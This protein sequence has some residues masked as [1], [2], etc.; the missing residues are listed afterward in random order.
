MIRLSGF[1]CVALAVVFV[2]SL[3][4]SHLNL[5]MIMVA[6]KNKGAAADPGPGDGEREPGSGA[7]PGPGEHAGG[8][9]PAPNRSHGGAGAPGLR[10]ADFLFEE[11]YDGDEVREQLFGQRGWSLA[12]AGAAAAALERKRLP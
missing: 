1:P 6:R 3:G 4:E 10:V 9:P 2:L 7:R 8:R 5:T 12:A 11:E